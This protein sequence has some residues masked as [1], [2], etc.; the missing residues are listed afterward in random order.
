MAKYVTD[1]TFFSSYAPR[2]PQITVDGEGDFT[3]SVIEAVSQHTMRVLGEG[4]A[5]RLPRKPGIATSS[6]SSSRPD[7]SAFFATV[8]S[9][10]EEE[11]LPTP[12]GEPITGVLEEFVPRSGMSAFFATM[13]SVDEDE[14]I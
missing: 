14:P 6:S 5:G 4:Y 13:E 1:A 9:V 7:M 8:E 11:F 2:L 3:A 12:A 10:D